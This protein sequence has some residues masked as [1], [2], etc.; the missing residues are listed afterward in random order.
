M[1]DALLTA[2]KVVWLCWTDI[3][4]SINLNKWFILR[5]IHVYKP[6]HESK[7]MWSL[8][9]YVNY[10]WIRFEPKGGWV[11]ASIRFLVLKYLFIQKATIRW[12]TS[13]D[14]EIDLTRVFFSGLIWLRQAG[15]QSSTNPPKRYG[16]PKAYW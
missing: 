8:R 2:C 7:L 6:I 10:W 9:S 13:L 4:T 16:F 15:K 5:Y 3:L 11:S 1:L 12:Q 14:P